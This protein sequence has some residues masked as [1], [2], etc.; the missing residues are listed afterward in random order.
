MKPLVVYHDN[1]ADGF[2]AAYAAWAILRAQDAAVQGLLKNA[3]KCVVI[4]T[5]PKQGGEHWEAN[6]LVN[7]AGLALNTPLHISE[8]GHELAKQSGTY[9][10]VWYL[11]AE[12]K[13][14]A[15]LRSTGD[16]DVSAIAQAF[17]GGGHRNAAGFETTLET[18]KEWLK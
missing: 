15:S 18:L 14:R 3:R 9:G 1:C 6:I 13:V 2:G 10:L 4:K 8:V 7:A 11:D 12:N 17:G 5:E 16:Y